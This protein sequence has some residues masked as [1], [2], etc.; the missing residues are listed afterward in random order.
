MEAF[1]KK[2]VVR[3][4]LLIVGLVGLVAVF[5]HFQ[6][7]A[8]VAYCAPY[9]CFVS[10]FQS[11]LM[12]VFGVLMII[13]IVKTVLALRNPD[14]LKQLYITETDERT[15]LIKQ[16]SGSVGINIIM[17]GLIIAAFVAGN[18]NNEAVFFTLLGAC[19]FVGLV[20]GF[21]KLYY[22]FKF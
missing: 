12:A 1:R 3:L 10:G 16:K 2:L 17:Y 20:C 19:W 22:R 6:S 5:I 14:R 18:F 4:W 15:L 11:G 13:F 21:F 9:P 7:C 8:R